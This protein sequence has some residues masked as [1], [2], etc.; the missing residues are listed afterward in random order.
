MTTT[1]DQPSP[2]ATTSEPV[3]RATGLVKTY[4]HVV[5]LDGVDLELYP[6]EVLAVIGDNGAG[7]STLIKCLSGAES[8]NGGEI[9]LDGQ[10]VNFRLTALTY[11]GRSEDNQLRL[12]DP[13]VSRRHVLV[14]ATPG[15]YTI[16]DL[17]SQNGTYVNGARVD[18]S[19]LTDGD[20]I[21]IGEINLVFRGAP[22][23]VSA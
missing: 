20:R 6:G 2:S 16:R 21:T 15:G 23:A 12:L 14:M 9:N 7:K 19:P 5:A 18:E 22:A 8:P 10:A 4:G 11:I 1:T 3:L 13:G 17:G